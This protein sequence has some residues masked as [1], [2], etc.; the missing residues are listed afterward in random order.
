MKIELTTQHPQSSYNIPVLLIDGQV[1]GAFD[2]IYN[3]K[4][5]SANDGIKDPSLY[6]VFYVVKNRDQF[7]I[8]L[9]RKFVETAP[10][11]FDWEKQNLLAE[12]NY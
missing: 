9:V 5:Y 10:F 11:L 6:A 12:I 2:Y 4:V 8:N 3:D 1:C 7:D